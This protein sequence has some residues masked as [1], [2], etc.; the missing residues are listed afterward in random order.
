MNG[1]DKYGHIEGTRNMTFDLSSFI[2]IL[3]SGLIG[4]VTSWVIAHW[5]YRKHGPVGRMLKEIK[6]VLPEYFHPIIY[7]QFY[8]LDAVTIAPSQSSPKD[9]DVPHIE[10][11]ILSKKRIVDGDDV[12][13]LFKLRDMGR[14]LENPSGIRAR[15][16][17]DRDVAVR[18]IG[19]GFASIAFRA[20]LKPGSPQSHLTVTLED[21]GGKR[22]TQSIPFS[23]HSR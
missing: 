21:V 6:R 2:N 15:D 22:K 13:V 7:P 16:H 17:L 1:L 20:E 9:L 8:S 3:L 14:N 12:E 11:A 4:V 18:S 5:Y 10:Y 23:I 19:L